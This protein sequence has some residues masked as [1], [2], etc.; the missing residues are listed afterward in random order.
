MPGSLERPAVSIILPTFNRA[1]FL[2]QAFASIR[3]QT[4]TDWELVVVDDGSTD[5]TH[6]LV[7]ELTRGWPQRVRYH[8]QQNQGAYGA[9]NT[10]L[11]LARGGY[12]AFFDSDDVWLSH[13]LADCTAA[14]SENPDVDWV[15]GACRIIR[16]ESGRVLTENTF[17][18]DGK[19]KPFMRLRSR[20]A[21]RLFIVEDPSVVHCTLRHGMQTGLQNA[22]IR[23]RVFAGRRFLYENRAETE[24][25]M[26]L[27]RTLVAGHRL[28]YFDKIHVDYFIHGENSSAAS[29]TSLQKH[30][31]IQLA[32]IRGYE[33][34]D[35]DLRLAPRER[36]ALIR[37]MSQVYFWNV[38]YSLL[39][40]NGYR[41]EALRMFRRGLR[42]RPWSVSYWKTYLLAV[43]R[44]SLRSPP[45]KSGEPLRLCD[46]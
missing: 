5:N 43:A 38:G 44:S 4:F 35:E 41:Q 12:I 14:L 20:R 3:S 34:L 16:H 37:Q 24:E 21:G 23:D 1:K 13:H 7:E 45:P 19:A 8:R 15:Y 42:L 27:V 40:R 39:W 28:G 10:G 9:R 31:R 32:F 2:P 22:V 18:V 36:R 17:Y 11:D 30:L 25:G 46:V 29:G 26:F 33:Q 6:Q